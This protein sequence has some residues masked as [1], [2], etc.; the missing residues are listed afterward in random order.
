MPDPVLTGACLC[1][2]VRFR[3][4]PSGEATRCHCKQCQ[5]WS[6]D[7]WAS[8]SMIAPVIEGDALRWFASSAMAERGFCSICGSS[9]FWRK[10]G[11]DSAEVAVAL[12]AIDPPSGIL[13]NRHIFTAYKGDYH[14]IADGLPQDAR[15]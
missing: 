4:S 11:H 13:L 10:T 5:R 2:S 9:L 7:T 1:G 6:G 14:D 12:G 15:E 8:V 3:G